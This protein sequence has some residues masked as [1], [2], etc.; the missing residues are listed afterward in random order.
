MIRASDIRAAA[1]LIVDDQ[2]A[3]VRLLQQALV[4]DGYLA[5]SSTTDPRQVCEL[6]RKHRYDLILLDLEMPG[7]DGFEVMAG[8]GTLEENGY[9]SVLVISAGT[10]YALRALKAG[11]KDFISKPLDLPEVLTRVS[12]MLEVRLLQVETRRLYDQVVAEQKAQKLLEK[13]LQE[14]K[15]TAEAANRAKS[16]F[17]ATMSHEIR[18]PMNGL[19]GLLELLSLTKLDASQYTTLE[20]ARESGRSL[21]RIIDDILDFSKIEAGKLEVRPVAASI[22]E[23]VVTVRDLYSGVASSNGLQLLCNIDPQISPALLV[24]PLRL[25]QILNNLV[26]NALKFTRKGRVEIRADLRGRDESVERIRF[27]VSD[28]G[29]GITAE[30]QALLF[31]P[32][33]QAIGEASPGVTGSGLGLTI[34]QRL[35]QMMGG[36]IEMTSAPGKGTSM[37]L[38]LALR[39]ADPQKLER[40]EPL[41]T[42]A[43]LSATNRLRRV[44]PDL[45]AA[46]AD[47]TLLLLVDDHPTNRSLLLRQVNLLGY[48]AETAVDGAEAL[49]QWKTGRFGAVITDCNMPGLNGYELTRSIRALEAQSGGSRAPIIAWTANA[50]GGEAEICF[51][52]GMDDYLAKP[53]DLRDLAKLLDQWLPVELAGA[54][55]EE[56]KGRSPA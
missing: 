46:E 47:G 26:S 5:V 36:T 54:H 12:N 1:I 52:A 55:C 19:L 2:A 18:T 31:Q 41:S 53:V 3:N 20:V 50:L 43:Q 27:S 38:D 15:E 51:A 49:A 14:A 8:L 22:A 4:A 11:A 48:A 34:S 42:G 37:V 25:R 45:A 56:K 44:A 7:M 21:Q 35:A 32:F 30:N 39:A 33:T 24:D 29:I 17:L 10:Q 13:A 28:T 40:P 23:A 6:H 9:L 16:I